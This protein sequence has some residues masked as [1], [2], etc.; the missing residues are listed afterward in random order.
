MRNVQITIAILALF[1]T[2]QI[3]AAT[4]DSNA[5]TATWQTNSFFQTIIPPAPKLISKT[6]NSVKLEWDKVDGVSKY[7]IKY[8]ETSVAES[9]E[10]NASYTDESDAVTQT[11]I[12]I[13]DLKPGTD[14]YFA[15]SIMDDQN[16]ESDMVSDE[17]KIATDSSTTPKT[18]TWWLS[19]SNVNV[20]NDKNLTVDFNNQLSDEPIQLKITKN[21]NS[22][23]IPLTSVIKDTNNAK[24]ANIKLSV[25]LEISSSYTL[26]VITA[27]DI[28]WNNIQEWIN[29]IREFQTEDTLTPSSET[30][31]GSNNNTEENTS[32]NSASEPES[33]TVDNSSAESSTGA[34]T[35]TE[36]LAKTATGTK[37]NMLIALALVLSF[38]IIYRYRKWFLK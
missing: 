5:N 28:N 33:S 6:S 25:A 35:N 38:S 7:I 3:F 21:S 20:I 30:S 37:E 13:K 24:M 9:K 22:S 1:F 26:T 10:L 18:T 16:Y 19:I 31:L 29:W 2:S 14:Y 17:I 27:K 15:L 11:W 12:E 23:D 32:L 4:W 36:A 8:S 34:N